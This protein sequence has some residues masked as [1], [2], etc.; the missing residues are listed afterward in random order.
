MKKITFIFIFLC[1][2]IQ[3]VAQTFEVPENVTLDKAEDYKQYEDAV[4][5]GTEWLMNTPINTQQVKRKEVN[6]FLM[7]WMTGSPDVSLEM[8]ADVITFMGCPDC[9]MMF[10]AGWTKLAIQSETKV[11]NVQ[12]SIQGIRDVIALYQKNKATIGKNKEIEKYIKL[13]AKGKLEKH[14]SSKLE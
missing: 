1:I 8:N 4:V 11:S 6:T 2:G 12:G 9:L 7:K 10:L 14:I 3:G 5:K 13:E